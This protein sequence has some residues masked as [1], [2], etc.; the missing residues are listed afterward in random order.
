M[1]TKDKGGGGKSRGGSRP[2]YPANKPAK[3][4]NTSGSGRSNAPA[5]SSSGKSSSKTA[6]NTG[7]WKTSQR[8]DLSLSTASR[9]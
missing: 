7:V 1:E 6:W 2:S 8:H 9:K 4:G 5:K 3:T